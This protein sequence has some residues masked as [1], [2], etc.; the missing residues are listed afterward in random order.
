MKSTPRRRAL[1]PFSPSLRRGWATQAPRR[2]NSASP[3]P[4]KSLSRRS[5][6]RRRA[7]WLTGAQRRAIGASSA[8]SRAQHGQQHKSHARSHHGPR[9]LTYF[10]SNFCTGAL[11]PASPAPSVESAPSRPPGA[12]VAATVIS[13]LCRSGSSPTYATPT[14][15][16]PM[17]PPP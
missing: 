17:P 14:D 13:T 3:R 4:K 2:A 9:H 1:A 8:A 15:G 11:M 16:P 6:A 10:D 7:A 12:A 5:A